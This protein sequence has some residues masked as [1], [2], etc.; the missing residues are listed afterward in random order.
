MATGRVRALV[1]SL[2]MSASLLACQRKAEHDALEIET[3]TAALTP[4]DSVAP[5]RTPTATTLGAPE[6]AAIPIPLPPSSAAMEAVIPSEIAGTWEVVEVFVNRQDGQPRTYRPRDPR[7]VGRSL[8]IVEGRVRFSFGADL[9]CRQVRWPRRELTWG[10][11]S[12]LAFRPPPSGAR[13]PT[14]ADFWLTTKRKQPVTVFP[15]CPP[16]GSPLRLD[17]GQWVAEYRPGEL[18]FREDPQ[19]LL[20][21]NRRPTEARPAP[22]SITCTRPAS[23]TQRAICDSHELASWDRSVT[24]ALDD[25]VKARPEREPELK[26][27]QAA[28]IERRDSCGA[29]PGCIEQEQMTRVGEL[30]QMRWQ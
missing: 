9:D 8:T 30:I 4:A 20:R 16:L 24:R 12:E 7:L 14:F 22:A 1:A 10:T 23:Q 3:V 15:L 6:E 28:Y 19:Y 17:E 18:L 25:F 11:L 27:S 5:S 21:L 29:D 2:I 26:L 13:R